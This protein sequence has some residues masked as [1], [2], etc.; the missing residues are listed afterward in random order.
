MKLANNFTIDRTHFTG[1]RSG[2]RIA[3]VGKSGSGKTNSLM[4]MAE[5][6][7]GF[8]WP[9]IVIDPMGQFRALSQVMPVI[10]AGQDDEAHVTPS[11]ATAPALAQ[12][13]V[14]R[15][16][17][18]V[19]DVSMYAE[20]DAM[21]MLAAFLDTFRR[22][23]FQQKQPEPFALLIDEAQ[24]Y[25]P[26]GT[27]TP[28]S[29]IIIDFAKR[30]R[31][32][33]VSL[34][35][36]TQRPASVDKNTLT[37]SNLMIA[38]RLTSTVDTDVVYGEL[39]LSKAETNRTLRALSDGEALVF[40][41]GGFLRS[42]DSLPDEYRRVQVRYTPLLDD[43]AP[44]TSS[45]GAPRQIDDA[46]LAALKRLD[47]KP[48]DPAEALRC[49]MEQMAQTHADKIAELEADIAHL[50]RTH[51]EMM[52]RIYRLHA[53]VL[54]ERD[55]TIKRLEARIA[56]LEAS[57]KAL[58]IAHASVDEVHIRAMAPAAV[59]DMPD[60]V[61]GDAC[62]V[63]QEMSS[64]ERTGWQQEAFNRLVRKVSAVRPFAQAGFLWLLESGKTATAGEIARCTGYSPSTLEKWFWKEIQGTGLVERQGDRGKAKH[65]RVIAAHAL[66]EQFPDLDTGNLLKQ[67]RQQL[68][69]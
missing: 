69:P 18:L 67:M 50:E 15:R 49:E 68:T 5:G 65:Y 13:V 53:Q 43:D 62:P 64:I 25:I 4:V 66:T 38:H 14:E 10:V 35:L 59:A 63:Q 48:V 52:D 34:F 58:T 28:L 33:N 20:D 51:A 21:A 41:D 17:S 60:V 56:E 22:L 26:Q 61:A 16:I 11:A 3:A 47:D 54:S 57:P 40:G 2:K 24:E 6:W 30:G 9:L 29:K 7:Y 32:K 19:L 1:S 42:G 8:G 31:H 23:T 27:H 12:I 44:D 36:A 55:A 46:L 39:P 37:Q 45:S